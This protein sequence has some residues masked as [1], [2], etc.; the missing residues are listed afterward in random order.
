MSKNLSDKK[1]YSNCIFID[2]KLHNN[3]EYYKITTFEYVQFGRSTDYKDFNLVNEAN[4]DSF[5]FFGPSPGHAGIM[6]KTPNSLIR[7]D[8]TSKC[9]YVASIANSLNLKW[10]SDTMKSIKT[11]NKPFDPNGWT[12]TIK[13]SNEDEVNFLC[14]EDSKYKKFTNKFSLSDVV[15][16]IKHIAQK[17]GNYDLISNGCI[18]WNDRLLRELHQISP[19]TNITSHPSLLSLILNSIRHW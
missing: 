17:F 16:T 2:N 6:L 9:D 12:V 10:T 13:Q 5:R 4:P 11:G 7:I 1:P 15:E 18:V 14:V 19:P 3:P 8:L